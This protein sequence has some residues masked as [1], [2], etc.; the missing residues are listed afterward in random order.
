[1][2][3]CS[4]L[5]SVNRCLVGGWGVCGRGVEAPALFGTKSSSFLDPHRDTSERKPRTAPAST[6]ASGRGQIKGI[7]GSGARPNHRPR[8]G[9]GEL[10]RRV[11]AASPALLP[12]VE[13]RSCAHTRGG[14]PARPCESGGKNCREITTLVFGHS[15]TTPRPLRYEWSGRVVLPWPLPRQGRA[16][17]GC[18]Q[19]GIVPGA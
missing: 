14:R 18:N 1:M 2:F 12:P 19:P 9:C 15:Q 6:A 11:N 13:R 17:S 16:S 5:C 10:E 8:G 3:S 7:G 4:R